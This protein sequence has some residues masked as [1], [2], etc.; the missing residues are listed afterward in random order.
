M[1]ETHALP[2]APMIELRDDDR[3]APD[4]Y[5]R[6]TGR[7]N[8]AAFL[9]GGVVVAGGLLAFLY[10]DSDNLNDQASRDLM[11]IGSVTQSAPAIVPSIRL[12]RTDTDTA[13]R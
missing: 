3:L 5:E 11:P 2:S 10:Y 12:S 8:F 6:D 4:M 13:K 7:S 1:G 9:M